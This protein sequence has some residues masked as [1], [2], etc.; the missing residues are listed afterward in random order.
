[1]QDIE[2]DAERKIDMK[3]TAPV[4]YGFNGATHLKIE[5]KR[6]NS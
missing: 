5:R 2:Q 6:E 3:D 4:L 1:M